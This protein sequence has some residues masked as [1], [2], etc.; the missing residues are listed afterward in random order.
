MN[1]WHECRICK[2]YFECRC[3]ASDRA[4]VCC[5][6]CLRMRREKVFIDSIVQGL[7]QITAD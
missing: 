2:E 3:D 1:H 4:S 7:L 5:E 6:D